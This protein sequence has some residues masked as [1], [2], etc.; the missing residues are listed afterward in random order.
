M[1][2]AL[3]DGTPALERTSGRI[4]SPLCRA[5]TVMFTTCIAADWLA[6]RGVGFCCVV[7]HGACMV[8]TRLRQCGDLGRN[9]CSP[10][11]CCTI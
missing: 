2:L 9:P 6:P 10:G 4:S 1:L 7:M 8:W 11:T 3:V 5:L